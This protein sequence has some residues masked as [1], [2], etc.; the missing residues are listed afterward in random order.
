MLAFTAG[1][2]YG[3]FVRAHSAI[4]YLIVS[5]TENSKVSHPSCH[6]QVD[7]LL[8]NGLFTKQWVW[9]LF[10]LSTHFDLSDNSDRIQT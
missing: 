9:E 5:S 4:R 8:S 1:I 7:P 6:D 10:L 3:R 2:I